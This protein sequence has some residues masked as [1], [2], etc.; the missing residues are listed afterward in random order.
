MSRRNVPQGPDIQFV[1]YQDKPG[2]DFDPSCCHVHM[3]SDGGGPDFEGGRGSGGPCLLSA[4]L[5]LND[6]EEDA[7]ATTF[8]FDKKK[9]G[10][11]AD[12]KDF[13]GDE[14]AELIS[15]A[16]AG[17][18]YADVLSTPPLQGP[19]FHFGGLI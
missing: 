16:D 8:F 3:D 10:G 18:M 2:E 11:K 7:G 19:S 9:S 6:V 14:S 15:D 13:A 5:Y 1:K 17:T 4:L 12:H